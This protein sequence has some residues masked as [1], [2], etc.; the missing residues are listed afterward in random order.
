[1]WLLLLLLLRK[2]T[3]LTKLPRDLLTNCPNLKELYTFGTN[4][5]EPPE[6]VRRQ[7]CGQYDNDN[8]EAIRAYFG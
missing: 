8:L 5:T 4:I 7:G 3:G 2:C 1:M 6:E